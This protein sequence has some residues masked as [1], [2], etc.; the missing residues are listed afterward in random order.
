[1]ILKQQAGQVSHSPLH[2]SEVNEIDEYQCR[3]LTASVTETDGRLTVVHRR[4]EEKKYGVHKEHTQHVHP[5]RKGCLMS[6][7]ST[8]KAGE[9]TQ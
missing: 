4:S 6:G 7:A 8:V 5:A 3:I 9:H 1:M 2:R